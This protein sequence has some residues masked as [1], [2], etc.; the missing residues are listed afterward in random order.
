MSTLG[1][2]NYEP[3]PDL[4]EYEY[5]TEIAGVE[6]YAGNSP[7]E[8]DVLALGTDGQLRRTH[9]D[10]PEGITE[11]EVHEYVASHPQWFRRY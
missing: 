1:L 11:N 8:G 9:W 3:T 5:L 2:S 4:R 10:T 7:E 6:F